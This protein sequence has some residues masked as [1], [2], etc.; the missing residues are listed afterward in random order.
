MSKKRYIVLIL[1]CIGFALAS[2]WLSERNN[3]LLLRYLLDDYQSTQ[4]Q[5][6]LLVGSSTIARWPTQQMPRCLPAAKRGFENGM[7]SHAKQYLSLSPQS[8]KRVVVYVG[9]NDLYQSVDTDTLRDNTSALIN[10]LL[11]SS[12]S[13]V[14]VLLV[15]YSPSRAKSHAEFDSFNRWL[16]ESYAESEK[17]K[18]VPLDKIASSHFYVGDGIH[19]NHAGYKLL[20]SWVNRMCTGEALEQ[21]LILPR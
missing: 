18:L 1:A 15:K 6:T 16:V 21:S 11:A 14:Y 4:G 3:R 20:S 2:L 9:E 8:P 7:V 13:Q 10:D 17:V 5:S 19:L 12:V